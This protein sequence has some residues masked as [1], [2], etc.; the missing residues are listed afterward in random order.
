[1]EANNEVNSIDT[2]PAM[3][4]LDRYI[5]LILRLSSYQDLSRKKCQVDTAKRFAKEIG[6]Y[7]S[8][9]ILEDL[10]TTIDSFSRDTS[11][12]IKS[13]EQTQRDLLQVEF[14]WV[15]INES[16]RSTSIATSMRR[17]SGITFI[18][19][20]AMFASS[21]FGMNVDLLQDNPD[22]RWFVLVVGALLMINLMIW[23]VIKS[24]P[25]IELWFERRMREMLQLTGRETIPRDI[26]RG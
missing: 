10:Q 7:H 14:A 24:N 8:E 3:P 25:N 4:Q 1:M 22:W 2:G 18:F 15:S 9:D 5:Q 20:P 12:C 19:L 16:H 6:P 21:L 23:V 17:L 11:E 13:L 26:E